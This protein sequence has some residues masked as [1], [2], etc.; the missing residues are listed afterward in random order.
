MQHRA[1]GVDGEVGA[2]CGARSQIGA[3]GSMGAQREAGECQCRQTCANRSVFG[4][5]V[6]PLHRKV[7]RVVRRIVS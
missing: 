6:Y 4:S 5:D 7:G 2:G 3:A 1:I